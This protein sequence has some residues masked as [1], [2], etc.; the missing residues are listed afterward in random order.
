MR[1]KLKHARHDNPFYDGAYT[2][3]IDNPDLN[4]RQHF[5]VWPGMSKAEFIRLARHHLNAV[6]LPFPAPPPGEYTRIRFTPSRDKD[7][8]GAWA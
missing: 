4:R 5:G 6:R 2:V 7:D 3:V 8:S 1:P